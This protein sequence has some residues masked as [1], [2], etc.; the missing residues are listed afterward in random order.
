MALPLV[1][2][3][4]PD[5]WLGHWLLRLAARYGLRLA[6]FLDGIELRPQRPAS[7]GWTHTVQW[8][9]AQWTRFAEKARVDVTTAR[10]M[11]TTRLVL[12]RG[13]RHGFCPACLTARDPFW[14]RAWMD[15][16]AAWCTEHG[17]PL[18]ACNGL[19]AL[20][21][22]SVAELRLSLYVLARERRDKPP[23]WRQ[24]LARDT[25]QLGLHGP[26]VEKADARADG[27]LP[28]VNAVLTGLL[29]LVDSYDEAWFLARELGAHSPDELHID[30]LTRQVRTSQA[31]LLTRIRSLDQRVWLLGAA[32]RI[33]GPSSARPSFLHE[34][35]A[36]R[37]TLRSWIW[38]RSYAW[39]LA[40]L[41]SAV[42]RAS[43]AQLMVPW[44]T[45]MHWTPPRT[46]AAWFRRSLPES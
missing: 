16:T 41:A 8:S 4:W 10:S 26:I 42:R 13:A 33:I 5:E 45:A 34:T 38:S 23:T 28:L 1:P 6:P 15:A 19:V 32:A 37:Q 25:L 35:A 14:R 44:T 39:S 43:T 46:G 7:F 18:A 27:M 2:P 20:G 21:R 36:T 9:E 29:L 24:A 17:G 11:Q 40:S 12:P 22:K 30:D 3:A 31:P